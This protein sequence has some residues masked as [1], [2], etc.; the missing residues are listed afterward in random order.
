MNDLFKSR[1]VLK[2]GNKEYVIFRLDALEKAGLTKLGK[3]PYSIRVVLEDKYTTMLAKERGT[4]FEVCV[5]SNVQ[6]G[7]IPKGQKH[8]LPKMMEAGLNVTVN[9]DDPSV[10]RI[11]LSHEYRVIC[12]D[13]GTPVDTLKQRIVAAAQASF[14]PEKDKNDLVKSVK[15]ELKL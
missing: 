10:S 1:D 11:S 5:T 9:T 2:V 7:V 14:L 3:L 8:P 6:S 12:S 13:L 4:V 15:K